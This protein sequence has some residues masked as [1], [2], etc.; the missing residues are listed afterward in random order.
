MWTQKCAGVI[1]CSADPVLAPSNSFTNTSYCTGTCA[2]SG[3]PALRAKA[4]WLNPASKPVQIEWYSNDGTAETPVAGVYL[5]RGVSHEQ[6]FD[7]KA[8][9]VRYRLRFRCSDI[10][11]SYWTSYP[12]REIEI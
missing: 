12:I 10:D 5:E 1:D 4:Q 2:T 8:Q 11:F 9:V 3:V 7:T 6:V